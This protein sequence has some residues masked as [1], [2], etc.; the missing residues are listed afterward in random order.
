M[1]GKHC[2]KNVDALRARDRYSQ[3]SLAVDLRKRSV[4]HHFRK[5]TATI[6]AATGVSVSHQVA[7]MIP[8]TLGYNLKKSH[9]SSNGIFL[10]NRNGSVPG[11]LRSV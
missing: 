9:S 7:P 3:R 10:P 8:K 4:D 1:I 6:I 11:T 2:K 5:A